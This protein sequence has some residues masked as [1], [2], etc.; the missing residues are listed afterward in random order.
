MNDLT[1]QQLSAL[2]KPMALRWLGQTFEFL[3]Q[4]AIPASEIWTQVTSTEQVVGAIRELKIRGAPLIATAALYELWRLECQGASPAEIVTAAA[5]LRESRPTAVNLMN[6]IDVFL[7]SFSELDG[8]A[9]ET[10]GF[11]GQW[12]TKHA[13]NELKLYDQISSFGAELIQTGENI[14][15]HC[16]TGGLATLGSGTALGVI[17][18]AAQRKKIHVYVDETRPLLQGG[19]L[20]VWELQKLDIPHTLICDNM[21]GFL[22]SQG[23]VNRIFVGADRITTDGDAANKIGTYSLAVLAFYHRVPFYIVAPW[24]TVDLNMKSGGDIPI[25]QR[26]PLE[27]RGVHTGTLKTQ[28]AP[29]DTPVW[30][31]SFDVT[32]HQLITGYILETGVLDLSGFQNACK[33]RIQNTSGV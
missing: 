14:L 21:A 1:V 7:K 12:V 25:E 11:V 20:T 22:M 3:D 28:W 2:N 5:A 17:G 10:P 24:G 31:P 9:E 8:K 19:R 6:E 15:T 27:V 33:M 23:R 18:K 26:D 16:N 13:L 29:A 4:T 32:P 30:N